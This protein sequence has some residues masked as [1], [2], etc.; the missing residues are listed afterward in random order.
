MKGIKVSLTKFL[1]PI[2]AITLAI[3]F[4]FAITPAFSTGYAYGASGVFADGYETEITKTAYTV[5]LFCAT[6]CPFFPHIVDYET[7]TVFLITCVV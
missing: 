1:L 7:G 3:L 4:V 2:I 5:V 6:T